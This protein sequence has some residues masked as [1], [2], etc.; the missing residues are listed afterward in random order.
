M[1]VWERVGSFSPDSAIFGVF[2]DH[3]HSPNGIGAERNT[4]ANFCKSG[5]TLIKSTWYVLPQEANALPLP[6][7]PLPLFRHLWYH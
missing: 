1:F 2:V 3:K 7:P 6:P 5:S 4:G